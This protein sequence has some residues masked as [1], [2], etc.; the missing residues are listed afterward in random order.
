MRLWVVGVGAEP[1]LTS[2]EPTGNQASLQS[3][4]LSIAVQR[5]LRSELKLTSLMPARNHASFQSPR[6]RTAV[7]VARLERTIG[8]RLRLAEY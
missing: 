6:L 4:W 2:L 5:S 8:R 7:H 3:P 1:K